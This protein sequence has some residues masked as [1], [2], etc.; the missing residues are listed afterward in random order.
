[1]RTVALLA[2]AL[3]VGWVGPV[4]AQT[5]GVSGRVV[6]ASGDGVAGA[7]V[8]LT[9]GS[10]RQTETTEAAGGYRFTNL[11][12]GT[13]D[14]TVLHVG[15]KPASRT[16]VRVGTADVI[17]PDITLALAGVEDAVVVSASRVE[18]SL[19]DAPA[20]MSVLPGATLQTSPA[21]NYG[22]VLRSVPGLN[23][24]QMSARDINLTSRRPRARSRRRS[25]RWW[26]DA[27]CTST[28]SGSS[29]GICCRRR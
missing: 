19:L 21:Q 13:Y 25:S 11:P 9:G 24:I 6:D 5:V 20:S 3:V 4:A 15:F 29:C 8:T 26:T 27:R 12:A 14:V 10:V 28:S 17:V 16:M 1:M 23:V 2:A 22:E 18:S 7:V